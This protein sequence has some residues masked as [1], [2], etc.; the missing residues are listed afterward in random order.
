MALVCQ[1]TCLAGIVLSIR[2]R[3][4]TNVSQAWLTVLSP[5]YGRSGEL[6]CGEWY[7]KLRDC[8]EA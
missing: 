1:R 8:H 6:D 5:T 3:A 7:K 4:S 2:H